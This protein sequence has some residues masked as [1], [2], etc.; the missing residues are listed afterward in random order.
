M[1]SISRI[2]ALLLGCA[3]VT[4]AHLPTLAAEPF[5]ARPVKIV[6]PYS[7]GGGTDAVTRPLAQRLSEITGQAFIV[8]NKPGA[9]AT[10]GAAQVAR[11]PA[12]G[13]TLVAV[14]GVPFLLNQSAYKN[15]PYDTMKDLVPVAIFSTVPMLLVT[16]AALPVDS[17]VALVNHAKA[18]PNKL[19]YAGTDQMTYLGMELIARGTGMELTYVPYKGAGPAV[20]DLL[21]NHIALMLSS[22]SAA[23]PQIKEGRMK[24][25]AITT[26][27]RS[28][29]LPN[30]PTISE[31]ILPGYE[32][33][34]WF[35]IFAPAATPPQIVDKLADAIQSAVKTP[36]LAQ[37]IEGQGAEILF[38]GPKEAQAFIARENTRWARAYTDANS[39]ATA[40]AP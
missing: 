7:V 4:A 9:D 37:Q 39:K 3:L 32:L 18:N 36:S 12:D 28:A 6:V 23:L 22:M 30:V 5:P 31:T 26:S 38:Y 33:T 27:K 17:A 20:T 11:G 15:L 29:A 25:L 19:D 8:D 14:S 10:I 2:C 1:P 34:A 13:Y 21:G 40:K 16:S 24:A 35:A